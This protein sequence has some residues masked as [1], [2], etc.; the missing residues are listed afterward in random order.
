M[1]GNDG[2]KTSTIGDQ[3][4]SN[5]FPKRDVQGGLLNVTGKMLL[6]FKV[7]SKHFVWKF[8]VIQNFDNKILIRAYFM[9]TMGIPLDMKNSKVVYPDRIAEI[10][11]AEEERKIRNI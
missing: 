2:S 1:F 3:N 6:P 8:L 11:K 10:M 5:T 9:K 7:Q 4:S